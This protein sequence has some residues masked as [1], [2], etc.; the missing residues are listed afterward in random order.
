MVQSGVTVKATAS[1]VYTFVT[2]T[3]DLGT[4]AFVDV[5]II[6]GDGGTG[7]SSPTAHTLPVAEGSSNFNFLGPL[8]NGQLLIGSTGTDPVPSVITAGTNISIINGNGSITIEGVG[9]ASFTWTLVTVTNVQ[10]ASN[11][12]YI[13]NNSSLV[14]LKLPLISNVGDVIRIVGKGSGGWTVTYSTGQYIVYGSITC[15]TT[16]GSLSSTNAKNTFSMVCTVANT[17]WTVADG[18]MGNLTAV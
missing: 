6:P 14:T 4:A 13:A 11:N 18:P 16:T 5:P 15:T 3:L 8:T 2:A 9:A 17:E 12:G 10:M 7:V 1:Q